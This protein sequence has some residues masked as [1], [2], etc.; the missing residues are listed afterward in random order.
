MAL[1]I[2]NDD[3]IRMLELP[4][5]PCFLHEPGIDLFVLRP[6][7]KKQLDRCVTT[8]VLIVGQIDDTETTLTDA[9]PD[10]ITFGDS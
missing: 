10:R 3:N 2:I 9:L 5:N 7:C 4:G 1:H 8:D 6:F